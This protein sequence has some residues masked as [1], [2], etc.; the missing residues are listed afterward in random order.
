ME[1]LRSEGFRKSIRTIS[2][3]TIQFIGIFHPFMREMVVMMYLTD[4]PIILSGSKYE[5]KIGPIPCTPYKEGL[6]KTLH[7]MKTKE[8]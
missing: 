4:E 2:K 8:Y 6:R 3:T 5:T 7:W 1:I